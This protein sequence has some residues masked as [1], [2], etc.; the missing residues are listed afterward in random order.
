MKKGFNHY[1]FYTYI[2]LFAVILIICLANPQTLSYEYKRSVHH[3]FYVED[4]YV[5]FRDEIRVKNPTNKDLYFYMTADVS[6]DLGLVAEE[7][8]AACEKD[9]LERAV[10]FIKARTE[11]NYD[12]Y[13]KAPKG[14]QDTKRDRLPPKKIMFEIFE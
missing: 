4:G 9:S 6:G 10:F 14:E 5:V 11:Q 8:A 12:V 2:G 3:E 1:I 13:F 7:T